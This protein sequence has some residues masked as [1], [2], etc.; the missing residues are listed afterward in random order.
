MASAAIRRFVPTRWVQVRVRLGTAD[1]RQ[2]SAAPPQGCRSASLSSTPRLCE[3][4]PQ[5]PTL[6][7]HNCG[8]VSAIPG[9]VRASARGSSSCDL[10][11]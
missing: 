1:E 5:E 4:K 3:I 9:R 11:G 8:F 2:G 7:S 10:R 6:L